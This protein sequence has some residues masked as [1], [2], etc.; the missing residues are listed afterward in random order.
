MKDTV[1]YS[2][3]LGLAEPWFVEAVKLDTFEG[4]VDIRVE[5]SHGVRYACR[6][7]DGV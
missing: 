2:R 6:F 5:R 4:R 3:I 1:L 7:A